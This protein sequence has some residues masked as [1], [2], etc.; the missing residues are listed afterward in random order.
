MKA[1]TVTLV[2]LAVALTQSVALAQPAPGTELRGTIT[3]SLNTANAYVGE[4]VLV[5]NVATADGSIEGAMM[6]GTVTDVVRAGQG[7]AA[8]IRMHFD[9]L[10]LANGRTYPI[11]GVV[12][13]AKAQTKSNAAKEV[14]GSVV[15][16][17]VGNALFK[18]L[19]AASGGGIIGAIGGFLVA[20]NNRQNMVVPA[21]SVV[22]VRVAT[23]RR[24]QAT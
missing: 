17:L 13:S 12:V 6:R 23:P 7:R 1:L 5:N 11:N 19:F 20:K 9:Y 15:G 2:A 22:A 10:T 8:Q 18:T 4:D 14:G 16:M 24:Q 3:T 21:G